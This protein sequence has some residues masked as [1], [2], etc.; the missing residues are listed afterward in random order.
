MAKANAGTHIGTQHTTIHRLNG[1]L[2]SFQL[3]AATHDTRMAATMSTRQ[4]ASVQSMASIK[5]VPVAP[6]ARAQTTR[7]SAVVDRRAIA[8]PSSSIEVRNKPHASP[9]QCTKLPTNTSNCFQWQC[10]PCSPSNAVSEHCRLPST[11][12]RTAHTIAFLPCPYTSCWVLQK[13]VCYTSLLF[14]A[15]H[16]PCKPCH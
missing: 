12:S 15:I 13:F 8:V 1:Q 9:N 4:L 3:P 7:S 11:A 5:S 10:W 6:I 16:P 14:H 2:L